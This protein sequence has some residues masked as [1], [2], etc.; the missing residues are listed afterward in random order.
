MLERTLNAPL[1][2]PHAS[3]LSYSLL[4]FSVYFYCMCKHPATYIL[5]V[6]KHASIFCQYSQSVCEMTHPWRG[7]LF[8]KDRHH[9]INC[10]R[11]A[12][13]PLASVGEPPSCLRLLGTLRVPHQLR[14]PGPPSLQ[15]ARLPLPCPVLDAPFGF[16]VNSVHRWH[17]LCCWIP[18]G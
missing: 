10:L 7:N 16:Y 2:V 13:G 9:R 14:F 12:V 8:G 17:W 18:S 5:H 15:A 3:F 1:L 11:V 4:C 6:V